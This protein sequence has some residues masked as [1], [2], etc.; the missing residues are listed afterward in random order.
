MGAVEFYWLF[1]ELQSILKPVF[2]S[3]LRGSLES[4]IQVS[5][6]MLFKSAILLQEKKIKLVL[7][8]EDNSF[9]DTSHNDY[10]SK[11]D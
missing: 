6:N 8:K 1:K 9:N 10:I 4:D 5:K 7:K 2:F 11:V 3:F